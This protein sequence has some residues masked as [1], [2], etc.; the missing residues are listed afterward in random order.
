MHEAS[1]Q[2]DSACVKRNLADRLTT[3]SLG[4]VVFQMVVSKPG[5]SSA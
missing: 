1:N 2:T 3:L 4:L 5:Q